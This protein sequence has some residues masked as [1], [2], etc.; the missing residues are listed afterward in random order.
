MTTSDKQ[1]FRC[2]ICLSR[3]P[4]ARPDY[5]INNLEDFPDDVT[6][7]MWILKSAVVIVFFYL[8]T[9]QAKADTWIGLLRPRLENLGV[10]VITEMVELREGV[11]PRNITR[12]QERISTAPSFHLV[13]ILLTEASS[14]GGWCTSSSG[15]KINVE[16]LDESIFIGLYTGGL[17][18]LARDAITSRVFPIVSAA[19]LTSQNSF[20][21]LFQAINSGPW[22]SIIVPTTPTLDQSVYFNLLDAWLPQIYYYTKPF[23]DSL[24][25]SSAR[26]HEACDHTGFVIMERLSWRDEPLCVYKLNTSQGSLRPFGVELPRAPTC[27]KPVHTWKEVYNSRKFG[28]ELFIFDTKGC[29]KTRLYVAIYT[30]RKTESRAYQTYIIKEVWDSST[31]RFTFDRER[32][33]EIRMMPKPTGL[34]NQQAQGHKHDEPWTIAGRAEYQSLL[35]NSQNV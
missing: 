20:G 28:E 3:D 31:Q 35:Q 10:S 33:V 11:K 29:C 18:P 21:P 32:M 22:H 7:R 8:E 24:I 19:S 34:A 2:P 6:A 15:D 1:P 13:V 23:K 16:A 14:Q 12:L 9:L 26:S 25:A 5:I 4:D 17:A 30:D 27:T